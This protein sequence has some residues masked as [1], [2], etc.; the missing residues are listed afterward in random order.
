[1]TPE[2]GASKEQSE[3]GASEDPSTSSRSQGK[4]RKKKSRLYFATFSK[5]MNYVP[6]TN[7]A[8]IDMTNVLLVPVREGRVCVCV[9]VSVGVCVCVCGV[10]VCE[11]VC[12]SVCVCVCV[13]L[14]GNNRTASDST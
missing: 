9:C 1:M 7:S 14:S 13:C 10:C 3:D 6:R 12:V 11:R 2:E 4:R 5:A 8:V